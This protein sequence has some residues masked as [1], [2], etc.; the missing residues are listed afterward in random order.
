[1]T[2]GDKAEA[3]EVR[4]GDMTMGDCCPHHAHWIR[5][6]MKEGLFKAKTKYQ[7]TGT[8]DVKSG[9]SG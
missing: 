5:N 8:S 9:G 2:A 7:A 4:G 6:T 3:N 1:M